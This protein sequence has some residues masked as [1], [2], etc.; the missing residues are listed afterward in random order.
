MFVLSNLF[1][2]LA[3]LLDVGITVYIWIVIA[4]ALVSWVNADPYNPIVQFL[5][6]VTDPVLQKIR[7]VLPHFAGLDFSPLVLILVLYVL[8]GFLVATLRDIALAIR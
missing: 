2:A 3:S 4:R 6:S 5:R 1:F 7:G 8:E